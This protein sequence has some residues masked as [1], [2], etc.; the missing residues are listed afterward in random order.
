LSTRNAI[1][2]SPARDRA[3]PRIPFD[4]KT[5][6]S[7]VFPKDETIPR[8]CQHH[9]DDSA[10]ADC[11]LQA[12]F[13]EDAEALEIARKLHATTGIVVGVE[14]SRVIDDGDY[15]GRVEVEP[16]LPIGDARHHLQWVFESFTM[17]S[18][19]L[20]EL[21]RRAQE[22][23]WFARKPRGVRFCTTTN[24]TTPSAYVID[25]IIT[26]NLRGELYTS[27]EAVF[28]TLVHELFHISDGHENEWSR[29][30][31]ASVYAKVRIR[32]G[33]NPECLA[34]YAPHETQVDGGVFY[35]FHPTSDVREYGAE[36]ATRYV[37]EQREHQGE[38]RRADPAFKCLAPENLSAWRAIGEKFFGGVDL[39][40]PC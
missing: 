37:R 21:Q 26:Y 24:T 31:L 20:D 25:G 35:A 38:P 28:E 27:A 23:I 29:A 19:V 17:L 10:F 32:C 6:A 4:R 39:V 7:H 8:A 3:T 11:L 15:R 12:R 36:L 33:V 22:P 2:A 13:A 18:N 1:F 5:L 16:A 34:P 30:A 14:A 40:P 9:G